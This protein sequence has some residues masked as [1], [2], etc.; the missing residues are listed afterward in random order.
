MAVE[1]GRLMGRPV[2]GV[3]PKQ[4]RVSVRDI[5]F[6]D[7]TSILSKPFLT[8]VNASLLLQF[9]YGDWV[10]P[11]GTVLDLDGRAWIMHPQ[12]YDFARRSGCE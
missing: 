5:K 3:P 1:L 6:K 4:P 12:D 9:G 10:T 8:A 11:P 2:W 7:G